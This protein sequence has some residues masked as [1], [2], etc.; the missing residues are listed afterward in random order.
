GLNAAEIGI[1][2]DFFRLGGNSI[3]AIKLVNRLSLMLEIEVRVS[4][5]FG[6]KTIRKLCNNL[7]GKD[8]S[9]HI[10]AQPVSCPEEQRLSFA[11]ERLWFIDSYE[12][13]SHAYNIPMV[14][15]LQA[16]TDGN[17]L[18]DALKMVIERHEILRTLI[19]VSDSGAGYQSVLSESD[20][21]FDVSEVLYHTPEEL[22]DLCR[23]ESHHVFSLG[24]DYPIR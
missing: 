18:L 2:D 4:D 16:G 24:E 22:Q 6:C 23:T 8:S 20:K 12:G 19:R 21:A 5:L 13:G 17:L 10:L 3:L 15:C 14:L 7:H 11:Q 9:L 1:D